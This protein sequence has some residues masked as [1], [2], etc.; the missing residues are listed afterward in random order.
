M[1]W[2]RWLLIGLVL[3]TWLGCG[4]GGGGGG[5]SG[6]SISFSASSVTISYRE[7]DPATTGSVL[8]TT[9]GST[10]ES[11]FVGAGTPTGQPDPNIARVEVI[12]L[13]ATHGEVRI[14]PAAGLPSG[15]YKGTLVA[16]ACADVNCNKYHSGTPF[17]IDYTIQVSVNIH[18]AP[19]PLLFLAETGQALSQNVSVILPPGVSSYTAQATDGAVVIDQLTSSGFRVSVP[20]GSVGTHSSTV[21]LVSGSYHLSIPL[22]Q[23]V[24]PKALKL[25]RA[26]LAMS[27]VSGRTATATIAVTQLAEGAPDYIVT[28]DNTPWL[29]AVAAAGNT[30]QVTAASMPSGSYTANLSIQSGGGH[31]TVPVSYVVSAPAGGDHDIGVS[32]NGLTLVATEGALSAP[33]AV[34]LTRPSW[35]PDVQV[36]IA[37]TEGSGWLGSSTAASG[38][39]QFSANASGLTK[40]VYHA[41]VTLTGAYPSSATG[42]RVPVVFTVGQGLAQPAPQTQVLGSDATSAVLTG[43][44]PVISDG[45]TSASWTATSSASWLR[46]TRSAGSLG[47]P[48]TYQ[49][50]VAQAQALPA[51]TDVAASVTINAQLAGAPASTPGFTPVTATVTLRREL[52][53]VFY[54][55]PDV[56]VAGQGAS[57]IVRGRGFDHLTNP[58]ARLSVNGVTPTAVTRLGANSL[59][60]QL[61]AMAAGDRSVSVSNTAGVATS[62]AVLHVQTAQALAGASLAMTDLPRT[63]LHDPLHHQLFAVQSTL[64]SIRRWRDSAGSWTTD[65]LALANLD[66]IG[67]SPDGAFLIATEQSGRLHLIDPVSF[68]ISASYV[69]PGP[70]YQTPGTGHGLAVTNDGKVWLTVGSTWNDMVTFDLRTRTFETVRPAV[71]T[72]LYSGPWYEVSRNGERLVAVQSAS[73]SPQ[74]PMLYMDASDGVWKN[75]PAGLTFFYWSMNGLDDTANRFLDMGVVYDAGF[76]RVGRELIPDAG[77]GDNAAVLSPDGTRLYVFSLPP[78]WTNPSSTTMPRVYVFDASIAAGNVT[79]LPLLGRIDLSEYPTCHVDQYGSPCYRPVMNIAADGKTLFIGGSVKLLVVPVPEAQA[80]TR[81]S[82]LRARSM[83]TMQRWAQ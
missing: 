53:E 5:E 68:T 30:I 71:S 81:V 40:G 46:L 38:D 11:V 35:N 61:P 77:W 7:G 76:N 26:S 23:V 14:V 79:D 75:N 12:Q 22:T 57:V 56:V 33:Q 54:V 17:N 51:Y 34:G 27:A 21:E 62:S 63:V 3:P 83:R 44:I 49:I 50:D 13:D 4:G 36:A 10:T 64:S 15:T 6:F 1:G 78:D 52:A 24:T 70:I 66:D 25:D 58:A 31:V 37:Y 60:V 47:T 42:V 69:A 48:L 20:A 73:I 9:H 43:T 18:A 82:P 80:L 67:M 39:L 32:S 65:V 59:R 2:F 45:S 74:P 55:G 8:A 19:N 28:T 41:T 72:S 16:V 29:T